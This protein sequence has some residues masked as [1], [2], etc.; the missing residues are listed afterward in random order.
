M[1]ANPSLTEDLLWDMDEKRAKA[2]ARKERENNKNL[3]NKDNK[4]EEENSPELKSDGNE[5]KSETIETDGEV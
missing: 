2:A 5:D 4:D 3:S 1:K